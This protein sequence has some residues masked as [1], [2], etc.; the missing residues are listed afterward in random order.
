MLENDVLFVTEKDENIWWYDGDRVV[1]RTSSYAKILRELQLEP[2]ATFA[3]LQEEVGINRSAI[4]KMLQKMQERNF[5]EKDAD[6]SWRVFITP[7]V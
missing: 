6:G 1:F 7:S 3:N 4:Q 2:K 5:I